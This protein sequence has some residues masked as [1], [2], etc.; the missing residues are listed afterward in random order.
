[1]KYNYNTTLYCPSQLKIAVFFE[2]YHF[3]EKRANTAKWF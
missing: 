1:M 3:S 2:G